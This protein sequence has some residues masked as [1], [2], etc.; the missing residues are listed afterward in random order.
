MAINFTYVI[1]GL[2]LLNLV[3]TLVSERK[4]R[5][6]TLK[7]AKEGNDSIKDF[8]NIFRQLDGK[9]K[10]AIKVIEA[11]IRT[12]DFPFGVPVFPGEKNGFVSRAVE[13]KVVD[14]KFEEAKKIE[15]NI[16]DYITHLKYARDNFAKA[17]GEKKAVDSLI[18]NIENQY[19]KTR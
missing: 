11:P 17:P 4:R 13:N 3:I 10:D 2:L 19:G 1:I 18:K 14:E 7:I 8:V 15:K 12:D 5:K 6:L 16:E 9:L